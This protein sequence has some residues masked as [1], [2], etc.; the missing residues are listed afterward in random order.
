MKITKA[1]KHIKL[2]EGWREGYDDDLENRELYREL[3]HDDEESDPYLS[4]REKEEQYRMLS[5]EWVYGEDSSDDILIDATIKSPTM[6][7]ADKLETMMDDVEFTR[8]KSDSQRKMKKIRKWIS[9]LS[10]EERAE[11][12]M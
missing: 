2:F 1:M 5:G 6:S 4:D 9:S 7:P 11:I 8:K 12:S 3:K 10:P